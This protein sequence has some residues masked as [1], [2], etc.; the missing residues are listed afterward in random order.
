MSLPKTWVDSTKHAAAGSTI[1]TQR[2][3]SSGTQAHHVF[4]HA[5]T[6][7]RTH[8]RTN[9]RTDARTKGI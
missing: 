8:A 2:N 6:H 3:S 9:E 4:M 5:G 7:E 1:W